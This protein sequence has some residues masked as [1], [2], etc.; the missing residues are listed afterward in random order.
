MLDHVSTQIIAHRISVPLG[1][2]RQPLHPQF[3]ALLTGPVDRRARL[4]TRHVPASEL[5]GLSQ[6]AAHTF[7]QAFTAADARA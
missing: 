2:I 6:A 3:F 4:G 5:R 1:R 7:L